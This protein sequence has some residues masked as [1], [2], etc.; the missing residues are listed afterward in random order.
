V[1]YGCPY[2]QGHPDG[3]TFEA[4]MDDHFGEDAI[5]GLSQDEESLWESNYSA[6]PSGDPAGYFG[7]L[8]HAADGYWEL[9]PEWFQQPVPA[10]VVVRVDAAWETLPEPVREALGRPRLAIAWSDS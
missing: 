9:Q 3:D 5:F 10:D 8:L 1:I 6:S 7:E 4:L 2:P